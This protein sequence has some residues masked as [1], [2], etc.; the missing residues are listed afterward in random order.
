M[1]IAPIEVLRARV[2][3]DP[4]DASKD[5]VI[6]A[7]EAA[8]LAICETYCDR[9]FEFKADAQEQIL[10]GRYSLLVKRYP[11]VSVTSI[12]REGST[13]PLDPS[14]YAVVNESG[15][16]L[17]GGGCWASGLYTVDYA[18]GYDPL[19]PDLQWALLLVFDA[20]W[21]IAPSGGAS[22]AGE[23]PAGALSKISVVGVG[24]LEFDTSAAAVGAGSKSKSTPWSIIPVTAV[25]VLTRYMNH[26]VIAGG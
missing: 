25:D 6:A 21:A 16:I 17:R 22:G 9:F 5:V 13:D 2:G 11:L 19:P 12:T 24:A 4:T 7:T 10:P 20:A 14:S 15:V 3:L 23:L 1:P 26:T 8:A 18:G